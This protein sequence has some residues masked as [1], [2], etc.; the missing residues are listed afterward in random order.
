MRDLYPR[1]F[2]PP[3]L[4]AGRSQPASSR[5]G[6]LPRARRGRRSPRGPPER[7]AGTAGRCHTPRRRLR[8]HARDGARARRHA[9][10]RRRRAIRSGGCPSRPRATAELVPDAGGQGLPSRA[11]RRLRGPA[12]LPAGQA[13]APRRRARVRSHGRGRRQEA[14]LYLGVSSGFRSDA[15]QARAVRG[16][17]R[18]EVGGAARREPAPLRHRARPRP[19]RRLR[20]ARGERDRASGS[21]GATPGSPGT[22]AT[23]GARAARRSAS[24]PTAATAAPRAPSSP[25]SPPAS[26]R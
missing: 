1:L 17:S 24:A 11:R 5:G 26:R 3:F 7:R 23:R 6:G 25:S 21:S 14:G 18:P 8:G 2:E 19:A 16:P 12:R 4:G 9:C 10:A 13:H 15:E 20:V 22:S